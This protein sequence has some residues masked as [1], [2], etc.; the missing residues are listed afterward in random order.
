M[1]WVKLSSVAAAVAMI[2]ATAQVQS[3]VREL[4]Y[5]KDGAIKKKRAINYCSHKTKDLNL[6][7]EITWVVLLA[8]ARFPSSLD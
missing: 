2:R 7:T 5:A 1:P 4:P 3:L 8:S 6:G